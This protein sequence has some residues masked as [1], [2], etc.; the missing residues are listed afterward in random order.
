MGHDP[1]HCGGPVGGAVV[2][3]RRKEMSE[4]CEECGW[5]KI[6][7]CC[8]PVTHPDNPVGVRRCGECGGDHEPSG[9]RSDCV[10]HWKLRA[11]KAENT[12]N[13]EKC[14]GGILGS[15]L[16]QWLNSQDIN[17]ETIGTIRRKCFMPWDSAWNA[18][19]RDE[20]AAREK[21]GN[22]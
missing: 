19:V 16:R 8:E 1:D 15:E 14:Y 12:V 4:N 13:V 20:T 17:G 2:L 6:A 22:A 11:I 10:L 3:E 9:A 5:P 7:C 18:L 21:K